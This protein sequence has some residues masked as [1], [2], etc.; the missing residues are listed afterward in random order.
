MKIAI[1]SD[2]HG[3]SI[4]LKVVLKEIHGMH[5]EHIFVLG[6]FVGYYYHPDEVLEALSHFKKTFVRGNHEDMLKGVRND[7]EMARKIEEKYGHGI[8]IA[9]KSLSSKEI[10]MLTN[11]PET[12]TVELG[13]KR[14]FLCHGSPWKNDEYIYPDAPTATLE[15]CTKMDA[16]F[17][18]MGHTHH[19]FIHRGSGATLVNPGSVGQARDHGGQA[20]WAVIDTASGDVVFKRSPFDIVPLIEETKKTDPSVKY[21]REVLQR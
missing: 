6:D 11:L 12:A 5:I 10:D 1:L 4:A 2:I 18:L 8:S 9:L 16:D 7:P 3:N 20:S 15:K 14:F 13:G 19:P 17:V 21:L